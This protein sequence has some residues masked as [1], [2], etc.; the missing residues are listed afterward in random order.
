MPCR[1]MLNFLRQIFKKKEKQ[2]VVI[3]SDELQVWFETQQAD[4][5]SKFDAV[6]Q[7]F[8][9]S[10]EKLQ[11]RLQT[12][13]ER[14]KIAQPTQENVTEQVKNI[15]IGHRDNFCKEVR[16]FIERNPAPEDTS[17]EYS[18]E[19]LSQ[20]QRALDALAAQTQKNAQATQHLFAN[21]ID[22]ITAILGEISTAAGTYERYLESKKVSH[23]K[24]IQQS[25]KSMKHAKNQ[26]QRLKDEFTYKQSR[27]ES[28]KKQC[29]QKNTEVTKLHE[30]D[31]SAA[32]QTLLRKRHEIFLAHSTKEKELYST[33][34]EIDRALRKYE[35]NAPE[36]DKRCIRE[37][38]TNQ[39]EAFLQDSALAIAAIIT[40]VQEKI[41]EL[42]LKDEEKTSAALASITPEKLKNLRE[43]YIQTKMELD[44][45]TSSVENYPLITKIQEIEYKRAHYDEQVKR[46]ESEMNIM[47]ER[48]K[49]TE[50]TIGAALQSIQQDIEHVFN[51]SATIKN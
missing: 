49:E 10:V 39:K 45:I 23:L 1:Y 33:F 43:K 20:L 14:L 19:F 35:Y 13:N 46:F 30:S 37:Y 18:L 44:A 4:Y 27:M 28:A 50:A 15:V 48:M 3:T 8:Y 26:Y 40:K 12:H 36:E 32:Y 21:E 25:I 31:D 17:F 24:K 16:L 42:G 6:I 2:K 7:Q 38:T 41:P 29:E 22:P 47:E 34:S 51:M 9:T 5:I 11:E